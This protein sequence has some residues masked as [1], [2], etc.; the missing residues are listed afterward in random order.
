[1]KHQNTIGAFYNH[2]FDALSNLTDCGKNNSIFTGN[3]SRQVAL[4][5]WSVHGH[6]IEVHN[7]LTAVDAIKEIIEQGE[8]SSPC[9]PVAWDTGSKKDLSHY[10]MFYSVAEEHEINVVETNAS[11]D[12]SEDDGVTDFI[13][14]GMIFQQTRN[15]KMG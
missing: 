9:N 1:M 8:G 3:R 6:T 12:G 5:G 2:I 4:S 15:T 14:V 13:K 10:F 11:L 7:Y